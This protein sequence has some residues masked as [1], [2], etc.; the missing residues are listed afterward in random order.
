MSPSKPG[1]PA[2]HGLP[3]TTEDDQAI[4]DGAAKGLFH[5]QVAE[6]LQR[7]KHAVE[8]RARRIGVSFYT[9]EKQR[10]SAIRAVQTRNPEN[11]SRG[12]REKRWTPERRAAM[13]E[14]MRR[15]YAEGLTGNFGCK[16]L[17]RSPEAVARI[18]AGALRSHAEKP[19][20]NSLHWLPDHKIHRYEYLRRKLGLERARLTMRAELAAERA[21]ANAA[22]A[23]AE[24]ARLASMTPFERQL[25]RARK[26][27][28]TERPRLVA[29]DLTF[30]PVGCALA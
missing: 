7:T 29:N 23:A 17:K 5:R 11:H 30:S 16:G 19:R 26:F 27:G 9:P 24:A 3:F 4:R 25:E 13:A 1:K 6:Q 18:K 12:M 15:L 14:R 20:P 8:L 21:A 2:R 28:I 10:L 22:A